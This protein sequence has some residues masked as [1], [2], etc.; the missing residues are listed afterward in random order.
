MK[1]NTVD[2]ELGLLWRREHEAFDVT[3]HS[4]SASEEDQHIEVPHSPLKLN[5]DD[6]AGLAGGDPEEYAQELTRSVFAVEKVKEF[7][8]TVANLADREDMPLHVRLLLDPGAPGAYHA[9]RWESLQDPR[10]QKPIALQPRMSMTRFV[11]AQ[12]WRRMRLRRRGD[13]RALIIAADPDPDTLG[14]FAPNGRELERIDMAGEVARAQENLLGI[15]T[16]VVAERGQAN[17]PA[18]VRRLKGEGGSTGSYDIVYLISHGVLLAAGPVLYLEDAEG[19]ATAVQGADFVDALTELDN[20]PTLVVLAACQSAGPDSSSMYDSALALGPK[21]AAAGVPAV[22]AMHGNVT[23]DTVKLFMP[24]FFGRLR[25]TGSLYEAVLQG[26][27]AVG[28]AN[29]PDWWAP[30]L[31]TRLRS[32]RVWFEPGFHASTSH[33]WPTF[34]QSIKNEY[35]TPIIGPRLSEGFLISRVRAAAGIAARWQVP[36]STPSQYDLTKVAQY[37][38]VN[39]KDRRFP[40]IALA[41]FMSEFIQESG[42][43]PAGATSDSSVNELISAM[44]QEARAANENDPYKL[45]AGLPFP[46]YFTTSWTN[47]LE[48]AL[49]EAGRP[50]RV[51]SFEWDKERVESRPLAVTAND[52]DNP[53]VF[54]LFG[55]F[56]DIDSIV[57]TEDDYFQYLT[58]WTLSRRFLSGVLNKLTNANLLLLGFGLD[59]WDFRVLFRSIQTMGGAMNMDRLAHV[60][61]QLNPESEAFEPEVV[62]QYLEDY[63]GRSNFSIHWG[64]SAEFLKDLSVRWQQYRGLRRRKPSDEGLIPI[65][66]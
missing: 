13:L 3:L 44:G 28:Q 60:A 58:N 35:C 46:V 27:R 36:V 40:R 50:A 34:L 6:F 41:D 2:L 52:P 7:L 12:G 55:N 15:S 61:V 33:R 22:L 49:E 10:D 48:D 21:L 47:L 20:L 37:L 45:L 30:V 23:V 62:Q 24:A 29:R 51:K 16:D 38:M 1:Q 66:T 64:T 5:P 56:D 9:L 54:R 65:P 57:L 32:G 11:N 14:D 53:V 19:K 17:L 26:R 25:E 39:Q 63:L 43:L 4:T 42:A 31:F 59:D 18:I 8:L